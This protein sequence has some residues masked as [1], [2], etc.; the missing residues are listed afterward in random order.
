MNSENN[1]EVQQQN[2]EQ[3]INALLQN[4]QNKLGIPPQLSPF[5]FPTSSNNDDSANFL[6]SKNDLKTIYEDAKVNAAIAPAKL[7]EAE[8]N[9]YVYEKGEYYYNSLKE[10]QLQKQVDNIA[11]IISKEF[12]NKF[13]DAST[14]QK[15]INHIDINSNDNDFLLNVLK[16]HNKELS[17]NNSNKHEQELINERKTYYELQNINKLGI[18]YYYYL[19]VYYLLIIFVIIKLFRL[20]VF[21]ESNTYNFVIV[22]LII[23]Y[24]F[25]WP[26]IFKRLLTT[27][28]NFYYQYYYQYYYNVFSRKDQYSS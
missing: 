10:Q 28:L 9:Y 2:T 15:Y 7:E 3:L 4:S 13:N 23:L 27:G 26:F 22:I 6:S 18:R 20:N 19:F 12:N 25:F 8:K 14:K 11:N 17:N 1:L 5:N 21:K 24:F 16:I